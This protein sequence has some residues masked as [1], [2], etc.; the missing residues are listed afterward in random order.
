MYATIGESVQGEDGNRSLGS[1]H[2]RWQ[3]SLLAYG[4]HVLLNDDNHF[5]S[6]MHIPIR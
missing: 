5:T 6:A 3:F 1:S 2:M 4:V